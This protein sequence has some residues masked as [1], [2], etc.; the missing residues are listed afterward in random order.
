M[1]PAYLEQRL[2]GWLKY[3]KHTDQIDKRS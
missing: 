2:N 1:D 3:Y